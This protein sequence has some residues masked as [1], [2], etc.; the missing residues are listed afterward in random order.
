MKN[1]DVLMLRY[2]PL[3][4][5]AERDIVP[6]L[7]GEKARDPGI[8]AFKTAYFG[9]TLVP[10][11]PPALGKDLPAVPDRYRFALS[12]PWIDVVLT[13]PENRL[14]IE[15]ALQALERGPLSPHEY[16]EMKRFGEL[17][18]VPGQATQSV[19]LSGKHELLQR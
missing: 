9:N 7:S 16:A 1:L 11:L 6:Y 12:N 4:T 13:G 3:H 17:L 14:Q 8:V 15:Q 5:G 18:A 2:N 10:D 19:N